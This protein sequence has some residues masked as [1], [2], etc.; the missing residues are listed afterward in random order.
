M[1]FRHILVHLDQGERTAVRLALATELATRFGARITALFAQSDRYGPGIVARRAGPALEEA[2]A[3]AKAAAEAACAAAGVAWEWWQ[4]SHGERNH[5]VAE[6]VI[7]ARYADLAVFGQYDPA[8]DAPVPEDLVEQVILNSGRPVL[9]VPAAGSYATVGRRA[10]VAWNGSREA[11]RALGDSIPFLAGADSVSVLSLRG[12]VEGSVA[13]RVP[14]VDIAAHLASHGVTAEV[15]LVPPNEAGVTNMILNRGAD[16]ASDLLVMG[17]YGNY[18][19][20]FGLRGSNT[21]NILREMTMPVL[22]AH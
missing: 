5:V 4:L 9:V 13:S 7:C 2:A 12:A 6:T 8:G 14:P 10:L 19:F 1:G 16:L 15:D 20:P 22:F 17:A 3:A 18:G 21:R 11:A